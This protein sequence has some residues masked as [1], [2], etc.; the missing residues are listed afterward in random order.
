MDSF[1]IPKVVM[2]CG[3]GGVGKTTC[4]S[5]SAIYYA[6]KDKRTLLISTDPSPSLSD[7]LEMEVKGKVTSVTGFKRLDAVE[8]DY[9]KIREKVIHN[10]QFTPEEA[11][12]LSKD[13][14][15]KILF[16]PG[17]STL[18]SAD[19]ISGRGMG[20]AIVVDKLREIGGSIEV[21]SEMGQG[22]TFTLTVPFSRAILKAQLFKVAGDLYAIPIENIEQIYFFNK[23]LIEYYFDKLAKQN[24]LFEIKASAY[25]KM[26]FYLHEQYKKSIIKDNNILTRAL[27]FI[28]ET[29]NQ[30]MCI[31]IKI[32]SLLYLIYQQFNSKYRENAMEDAYTIVRMYD[33]TQSKHKSEVIHLAKALL[34]Q[35]DFNSLEY[36]TKKITII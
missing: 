33:F 8:L 18:T 29:A 7:I 30:N 9:E 24:L 28:K 27:F 11:L 4:A 21:N 34:N 19:M 16:T 14:L 35:K 20:L 26:G 36:K 22:T 5:A 13:E 12:E 32:K 25:Q 15:N 10:G 17:F 1:V 3:K 2:F 31:S 23:E 6:K